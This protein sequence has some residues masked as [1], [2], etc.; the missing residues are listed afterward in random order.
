MSP[1]PF[2]LITGASSGIGLALARIAAAEGHDLLLVSDED[3]I[4]AVAAELGQGAAALKVD[5]ATDEGVREVVNAVSGRTLALVAA[6]AGKGLGHDFVE[7]SFED[8]RRV[9]DTNITGTVQLLHGLVPQMVDEGSGHIL[10]TG[11]IAGYMTGPGQAIYNASKAFLNLFSDSLGEELKETGVTVTCLQPGPTD[12]NIFE[13]A[14]LA[15][16]PIGRQ[17]KDDPSFVA[18]VGYDAAMKGETSVVSGVMNK[19]Q[20][21]GA[22]FGPSGAV[23]SA[24]R[25][26]T[27]PDN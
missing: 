24:H 1:A 7:Q 15:D 23:A 10:I 11:S 6:N 21:F 18:Q 26:L 8:I 4:H 17:K 2:A 16:S 14:G 20:A 19:L 27:D 3:D 25:K 22:K 5:L 9:I 13:N 12:T